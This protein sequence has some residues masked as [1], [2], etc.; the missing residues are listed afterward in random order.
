MSGDRYTHEFPAYDVVF[1]ADR[2]RRSYH[3]LHGELTVKCGLA[4]ARTINGVLNVGDPNVPVEHATPDS[5]SVEVSVCLVIGDRRIEEI[6]DTEGIVDAAPAPARGVS[7]Y[8]TVDDC[9]YSPRSIGSGIDPDAATSSG[10][11]GDADLSNGDTVPADSAV[12]QCHRASGVNAPSVNFIYERRIL[13]SRNGI[14][15]V[16]AHRGVDESHGA[17]VGY[18]SPEQ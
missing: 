12:E 9:Q 16:S 6:H 18:A 4:G 10:C 13:P 14:D 2:L 17:T 8:R 1:E 5:A 15:G 7:T 11:S 3:E